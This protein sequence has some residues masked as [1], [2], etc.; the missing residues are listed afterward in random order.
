M[1]E[2][3]SPSMDAHA[4]DDGGT[5]RKGV[6]WQT[7]VNC[8]GSYTLVRVFD[9]VVALPARCYARVKRFL[10]RYLHGFVC[11]SAVSL[12]RKICSRHQEENLTPHKAPRVMQTL[13]WI[14][15]IAAGTAHQ[16]IFAGEA[17]Q[18]MGQQP[19]GGAGSHPERTFWGSKGGMR[20]CSSMPQKKPQKEASKARV[21]CAAL[22]AGMEMYAAQMRVI[23]PSVSAP[24]GLPQPNVTVRNHTILLPP[25]GVGGWAGGSSLTARAWRQAPGLVPNS[26]YCGHIVVANGAEQSAQSFTLQLGGSFPVNSSWWSMRVVRMFDADYAITVS[27]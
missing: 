4:K 23:L 5:L 20:K 14:S 7:M 8:D 21:P 25:T 1:I 27:P 12:T 22:Y 6:P 24:F 11:A 2:N 19:W 17:P 16:L 15:T 10:W 18:P 9:L 3:Y 13:L 26:T